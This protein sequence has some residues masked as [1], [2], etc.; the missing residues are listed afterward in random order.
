MMNH[1]LLGKDVAIA[2]G[3]KNYRDALAKHVKEKI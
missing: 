2:I 3:Y 1:I